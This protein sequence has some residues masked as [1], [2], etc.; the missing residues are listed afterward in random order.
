MSSRRSAFHSSM[1][2]DRKGMALDV[3]LIF[4]AFL[5]VLGTFLLLINMDWV[6]KVLGLGKAEQTITLVGMANRPFM[7]YK[8]LE[9]R[10]YKYIDVHSGVSSQDIT[11]SDRS[12]T[13]FMTQISLDKDVGAGGFIYDTSTYT[14]KYGFVLYNISIIS[15]PEEKKNWNTIFSYE[16]NPADYALEKKPIHRLG[17]DQDITWIAQVPLFYKDNFAIMEITTS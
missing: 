2:M 4:A 13:E 15:D 9:S 3:L 7:L 6:L 16:Y 12:F 10:D 8:A 1:R 5:F 17:G 11:A 14:R